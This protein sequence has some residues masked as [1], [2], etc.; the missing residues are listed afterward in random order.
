[1]LSIDKLTLQVDYA[2]MYGT[3]PK[4]VHIH[5][6]VCERLYKLDKFNWNKAWKKREQQQI[7][8]PREICSGAG[9]GCASLNLSSL[10]FLFNH[11]GAPS[12]TLHCS[13]LLSFISVFIHM[14]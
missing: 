14:A 5:Y 1:M 4:C 9:D 10:D 2:M 11:E 13:H 6:F 12:E 3:V 7:K 8:I